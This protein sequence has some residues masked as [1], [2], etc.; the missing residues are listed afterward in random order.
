MELIVLLA[1]ESD[2]QTAYNH[3]E[4]F[5]E[6]FGLKFIQGLELAYEYLRHHPALGGSIRAIGAGF[7]SRDI[8]LGSST[9]S[10]E[11]EL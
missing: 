9:R 6:G 2:I 8:L 4:D 1:A 5:K 7:C 3:F 10:R 11:A